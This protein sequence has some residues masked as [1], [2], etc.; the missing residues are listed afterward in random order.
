MDLVGLVLM[1][2]VVVVGFVEVVVVMGLVVLGI[3]D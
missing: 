3:V 2:A 1:E